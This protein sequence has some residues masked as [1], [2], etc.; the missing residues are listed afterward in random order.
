M[1]F[2]GSMDGTWTPPGLPDE[3]AAEDQP[4]CQDIGQHSNLGTREWEVATNGSEL[5]VTRHMC[6][7]FLLLDFIL[8]M[9][10]TDQSIWP[11]ERS[12]SSKSIR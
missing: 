1:K 6:F 12:L 10:K 2:D 8:R 4:R 9:S 3:N 11:A 5:V 7:L